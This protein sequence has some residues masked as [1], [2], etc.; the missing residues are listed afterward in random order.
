[1]ADE[2]VFWVMDHGD[3]SARLA[4]ARRRD[5]I[6]GGGELS[7]DG[8]VEVAALAA[9]SSQTCVSV[10]SASQSVNLFTNAAW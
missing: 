5:A 9:N 3:E 8:K 2:P 6:V 7:T 10:A 1:M 4:T